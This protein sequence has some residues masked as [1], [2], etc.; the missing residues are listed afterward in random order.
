MV[1]GLGPP[2][3]EDYLEDLWTR[4]CERHVANAR[5][6]MERAVEQCPHLSTPELLRWRS[7]LVRSGR[8]NRTANLLVGTARAC[9]RWAIEAHL[10]SS[11]AAVNIRPLPQREGDLRRRR[12]AMT[13]PEIE[14]FLRSASRVDR[15][16]RITQRPLWEALLE[17]GLRF[18]EATR[19]RPEDFSGDALIV[20][21][22]SAKTRRARHVPISPKLAERIRG[23]DRAP[24]FPAPSGVPWTRTNHTWAG[25]LFRRALAGAEIP[26]LD[27]EGRRLDIHS[28]RATACSRMLRRAVPLAHV[29]RMLGHRDA[30]TTMRAYAD[31]GIEDLRK[32]VSRAWS[33]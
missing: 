23:L 12:R 1:A 26:R 11:E 5:R 15:G 21:A 2:F 19:L 9:V 18:G 28:L 20:R 4:C 7:R 16:L 33:G 14:R 22:E 6:A 32:E 10:V 31:L 3:V 29:A 8:S 13:D 24:L 30:R 27:D 25:K 17:T